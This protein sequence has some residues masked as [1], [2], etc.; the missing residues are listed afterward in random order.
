VRLQRESCKAKI[1][2]VKIR[3]KAQEFA[4]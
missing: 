2:K 4:V 3:V 1:S